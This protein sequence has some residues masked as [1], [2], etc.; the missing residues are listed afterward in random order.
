MRRGRATRSVDGRDHERPSPTR[1]SWPGSTNHGTSATNR[2]QA[3]TSTIWQ[4]GVTSSAVCQRNLARTQR[5]VADR[6]PPLLG[7]ARCGDE[8]QLFDDHRPRRLVRISK[9]PGIG[10][11]AATRSKAKSSIVDTSRATTMRPSCAAHSSTAG[12]SACLSPTS[13]RS[14]CRDPARDGAGPRGFGDRS[15][16]RRET[17]S[18]CVPTSE[19][20]GAEPLGRESR[21]PRNGHRRAVRLAQ[22]GRGSPRRDG[23]RQR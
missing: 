3:L 17:G 5:E 16:R 22:R 1:T 9:T 15:S 19:Q 10:S 14:R 2:D 12:S 6:V 4:V 7:L 18:S 23:V 13:A 20:L 21:R 11:P 8:Q